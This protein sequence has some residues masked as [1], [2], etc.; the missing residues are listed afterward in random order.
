M[1]HP[2][3]AALEMLR[4]GWLLDSRHQQWIVTVTVEGVPSV[5]PTGLL[6]Q[7]ASS[8]TASRQIEM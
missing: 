5:A 6:K 4:G 1:C 2:C 8:T 7:A 3:N